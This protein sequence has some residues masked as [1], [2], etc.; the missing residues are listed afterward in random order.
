MRRFAERGGWWVVAQVVVFGAVLVAGRYRPVA[1]LVGGGAAT[2]R[3]IL[4]WAL[5]SAGGLLASAA[6]LHLGESLTPYP[7]PL[8]GARFASG[9]MYRLVRHP[10]YGGVTMLAIGYG[11][12][13]GDLLAVL[14]AVSL[15]PFFFAKSTFEERHLLERYPEYADYRRRVRHRLLPGLL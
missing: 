3:R 8:P 10:I 4:G 13:R 15:V 2:A 11:L 9:G 5:I 6:M 12:V 14:A 7:V 1:L